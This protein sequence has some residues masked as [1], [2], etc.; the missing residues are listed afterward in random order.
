[1]TAAPDVA[2]VYPGEVATYS[3]SV[4]ASEGYS[5]PVTLNL[6]GE[7]G[8]VAVSFDP[9]PVTPPGDSQLHVT[10]SASTVAGTYAMTVTGTSGTLTDT[11]DLTLIVAS[12]EPP[13]FMLSVFPTTALAEPGEVATY[14]VSVSAS[15][16][17]T[18]P[19]ALDLQGEPAEAVVSFGPNLVTPPGNSQ[20]YV[21]TVTGTAGALTDTADLTLIVASAAPLSFT[22]DISPTAAIAEP[23]EVAT[24]TVSVS[25]SEGFTEPVALDLQGE[26][27]EAVVSFGP[28]LVTPPGNSQLYVTTT[29]ST[30][31]GVYAM[32]VTGT[33]GVLTDTAN[34][35]LIV[36]SAAPLSFTLDISPTTA[37]A[38]PNQSVS[39]T[40]SVTGSNGFSQPVSL[41]VV[42]L[43]SGVS[44]AWSANPV[45]PD[46]F[47]ILTLSVS[48]NPSFG[49][50]SLNIVGTSDTHVVTRRIELVIDYPYKSYL[51][52]IFK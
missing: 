34:L 36:T 9:N 38:E 6:Q 18:E 13:S 23:G 45:T 15:E 24:Y 52:V 31:A 2:S 7:P 44:A 8:G 50:H 35:T 16:G 1:V 19:V 49:C 28:N 4:T 47:S 43:P 51:P 48:S 26:P 32:T 20:L 10:T 30:V 42:R 12:A 41:T 46:D 3:I 22:L 39:F 37:V 14:T 5:E 40:V 25:A 17:F 11:A 21:T 33:S 29:V 27:A